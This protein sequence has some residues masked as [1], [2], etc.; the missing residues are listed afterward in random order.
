MVFV[1]D[2][3]GRTVESAFVKGSELGGA[4]SNEKLILFVLLLGTGR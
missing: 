2:V 3:A 4:S 1:E